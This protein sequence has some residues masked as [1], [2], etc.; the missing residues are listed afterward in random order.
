MEYLVA[1]STGVAT[2]PL[3]W[4]Q[5]PPLSRLSITPPLLVPLPGSSSSPQW[6]RANA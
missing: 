5:V 1:I 2:V 6:G 4:L 3:L